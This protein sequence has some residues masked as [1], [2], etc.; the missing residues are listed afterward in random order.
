MKLAIRLNLQHR[1][2]AKVHNIDHKIGLFS[3]RLV[4]RFLL[5][6]GMQERQGPKN[7]GPIR[8]KELDERILWHVLKLDTFISSGPFN[9]MNCTNSTRIY[10]MLKC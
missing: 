5:E 9:V 3:A 1:Y 6:E 10:R 7:Y 2:L 4:S 8:I